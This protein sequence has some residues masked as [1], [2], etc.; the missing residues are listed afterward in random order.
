MSGVVYVVK[1][2]SSVS[3]RSTEC[4]STVVV[5]VVVVGVLMSIFL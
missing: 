5:P 2:Y 4:M 3:V 1:F